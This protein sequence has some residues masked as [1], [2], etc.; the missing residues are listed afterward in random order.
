MK[1]ALLALPVLVGLLVR[2]TP[3]KHSATA[4]VPSP[5]GP[6]D[7]GTRVMDLVDSTRDDPFLANGAKRELLVRFWYPASP[8]SDCRPAEYTSS[9]VWNY[10]SEL[11]SV[12]LPEVKTNSCLDAPITEGAHP[13][14]LFSHGYTGAFTDYTFI[15]ED[16]A[17]RGYVVV[18][19]DHT[20]E[21]TA[22]EFPDGRFVKSVFGSYLADDTLRADDQALFLAFSA[23][24]RDLKFV[25]HELGRLNIEADS[26]FAGRLDMSRVALAGHSMG[27]MMALLG[28][29]RGA[30]FKAGIIIDSMVLDGLVRPTET[31]VLMLAAGREQ[32]STNECRLWNDLRGPRLAVNLR[33]AEHLTPS[34]AIFLAKGEVKTGAMGPEKTVAAVRGYI[35]AFLDANVRGKSL[36]PL[37]AGPSPEYPDAVVTTREQLLCG[38]GVERSAL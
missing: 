9:R 27:G 23:R 20:F 7:V 37:L 21:A 5:T 35:G 32:W 18:S 14:V 10:F 36:D 29:E 38:K 8:R 28:I 17:S 15:S 25:L 4:P 2:A 3:S 30:G 6:S 22:V 1:R 31:P 19:V 24:W 33:G 16:L 13:V 26:P 12:P 11:V 34:D